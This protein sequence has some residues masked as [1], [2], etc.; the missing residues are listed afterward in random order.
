MT[1]FYVFA[2][3]CE[4]NACTLLAE[5]AGAQVSRHACEARVAELSQAIYDNKSLDKTLK[6]GGSYHAACV[7]MLT[8]FER[9]RDAE[10]ITARVRGYA[11]K[12]EN[13]G[14]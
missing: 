3:V 13:G 14:S 7:A 10:R 2:V 9:A 11:A 6:A 5:P 12:K 4:L 8:P 1:F